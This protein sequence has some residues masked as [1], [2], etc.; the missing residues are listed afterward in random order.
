MHP[1]T[2]EALIVLLALGLAAAA[3]FV[4]WVI[5]N[6]TASPARPA[7]IAAP[8]G[9]IGQ[10]LP[11]SAFGDPV[12]GAKLFVSKR[13][14]DCHSFAGKGGTDAPPLDFM[15][16][17]LSAAEIAEMSGQIW[18]H[19]PVMI[20]HFKE[21]GIP[22]PTFAPGEMADLVSYLHSSG[23]GGVKIGTTGK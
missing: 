7:A 19:L 6:E 18:N 12:H 10:G 21:E 16:G 2:A 14:A 20:H 1:Y 3:A 23:A 8:P 17:H 4:G 9:H 5:G 11:P 13:C 22:N 15:R